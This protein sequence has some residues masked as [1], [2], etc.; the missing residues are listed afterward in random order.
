M[1]RDDQMTGNSCEPISEAIESNRTRSQEDRS[2]A[3]RISHGGDYDG[4]EPFDDPA[5]EAIAQF[6]AT[7]QQFRRF[8]SVSALAER[9]GVSRMTIYRRAGNVDVV[10]RIKWLIERSMRFGDLIASREWAGIVQAQ[11]DAALAGDTRAAMFCMNRAWRQCS[12]F[13]GVTVEPALAGA[14]NIP[15]WLAENEVSKPEELDAAKENPEVEQGKN[16]QD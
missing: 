5:Y 4:S 1:N 3:P 2:D 14:K 12:L 9:F 16:P 7:P 10:Q 6:F 13:D 8:K 15:T 11:V